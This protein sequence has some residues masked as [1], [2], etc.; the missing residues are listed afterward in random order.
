METLF[1]GHELSDLPGVDLHPEH[2]DVD[3][4][5]QGAIILS[6]RF[7][8]LDLLE[9]DPQ[10][11]NY[12]ANFG[13]TLE[14]AYDRW[15]Y[16]GAID[17]LESDPGYPLFLSVNVN[18]DAHANNHMT[19]LKSRLDALG[20]DYVYM[21]D[22]EVLPNPHRVPLDPLIVNAMNRY[23][24]ETL[25]TPNPYAV[26]TD[27]GLQFTATNSSMVEVSAS[28]VL[29]PVDFSIEVSPDLEVWDRW[30]SIRP[31]ADGALNVEI[32]VEGE[33]ASFYRFGPPD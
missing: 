6:G 22:T 19:V 5:V 29:P 30:G 10:L 1:G 23:L 2:S 17:F 12:V 25:M 4:S 18:E 11:S 31:D 26:T 21:P 14:S 16:M 20:A 32:P 27:L 24:R 8:Y 3:P 15:K 33:A 9:D 28:E 7:S 13:G